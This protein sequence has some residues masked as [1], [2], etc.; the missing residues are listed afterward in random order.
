MK[1][2]ISNEGAPRYVPTEI[3]PGSSP[4]IENRANQTSFIRNTPKSFGK[5]S[6]TNQS[7][8]ALPPPANY[9]EQIGITFS[10]T[11]T[12]IAYNVTAVEQS[13]SYGYG[14]AYLLNGLSDQGYWYQVGLSWDWPY[15]AGGYNAGFNLNYEVFSSTGDSIFPADGS[16]G[17]ASYSGIVNQG[18]SVLLDLYFSNGQVFMY[19]QDWNTGATAYQSFSSES[20]TSFVGMTGASSNSNGFFTGL[21]TEQYHVSA[22]YGSESDVTYTDPN[23]ALSSAMMWADEYNANTSQV[24]FVQGSPELSYSNPNQ[25]QYFSTNGATAASNAYEFISGPN[26]LT[27]I[28]FSY[29]IQAGGFGY[30]PPTLTYVANG[31]QQTAT[32]STLPTVYYM[33]GG[34]SWSATN[35]LFGSNSEEKWMT[36]QSTAGIVS[37]SQTISLVY[38]HQYLVTVEP[39]PAIGGSTQPSGSSWNI[40]GSEIS[41]SALSNSPYFFTGWNSSSSNISISNKQTASTTATISGYG[42]I[43][44][45]FAQ[46]TMKLSPNSGIVTQGASVSATATIIGSTGSASLSVSGL[47]SGASATFG[48]NPV[49]VDLSGATDTLNISTSFSTQPGN[50]LITVTATSN[51]GSGTTEYNLKI[52]QA[53]PMT[54]GFSI[55]DN[56]ST[57]EPVLNF[58]YNGVNKA[59][60]LSIIPKT[61][62]LDSGTAWQVSNILSNS[63]SSERWITNQTTGGIATVPVTFSFR[64]FHQ[65]YASFGYQII[66]G[67]TSTSSPSV[68]FSSLGAPSTINATLGGTQ[69]WVDS[70]SVYSFTTEISSNT[71]TQRW[72]LGSNQTGRITKANTV[73]RAYYNQFLVGV[74]FEIKGGGSSFAAPNFTFE[75][76]GSESNATMQLQPKE[77]WIDAG[78]PWSAPHTLNSSISGERW[79][80]ANSSTSGTLGPE[81]NSLLLSYQNQYY[82]VMSENVQPGGSVQPSNGWYNASES[83]T[84]S[85]TTN[86]GWKFVNWEGNGELSSNGSAP[87]TSIVRISGPTNETAEYYVAVILKSDSNGQLTYSYGGTKGSVAAGSSSTIY[88]PPGTNV[89]FSA[90]P[91]SIIYTVNTWSVG[92]DSAGVSPTYSMVV[93]TPSSVG[94]SFS[95]NY[96]TF[97]AIGGIATAMVSTV[98]LILWKKSHTKV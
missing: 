59:V 62:Y 84:I 64:Y 61:F 21:M 33:D 91:S 65:F 18:D 80:A 49:I 56:G 97:A 7:S 22:Y 8:P 48:T 3:L 30:Y 36:S 9:D 57:S 11:F 12:S 86:P 85:A 32:L 96:L 16:G 67:G 66:G 43:Y 69:V 95:Y 19:S 60:L 29:S 70:R 26:A 31:I 23:F 90:V 27:G 75:S 98:G 82:V 52:N 79:Q 38:D 20:A 6:E 2:S 4:L 63:S 76:L 1:N 93:S 89:S 45:N 41:I 51:G 68:T 35:P 34:S 54:F 73:N 92:N 53:V 47:P 78:S 24:L 44:G 15:L 81:Q 50:Y 71:P 28:T 13:D 88:V 25:L 83:V 5:I 10:Q 37:S 17:F 77:Y 39:N 40:A 72:E 55:S 87:E 42:T 58:T 94:V 74:S 46:V 14:P